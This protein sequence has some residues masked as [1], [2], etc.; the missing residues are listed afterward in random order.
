MDGKR[1][2]IIQLS[3]Q[4]KFNKWCVKPLEIIK[5]IPNGDGGF[6]ALVY[7]CHLYEKYVAIKM[8]KKKPTTSE[9]TG[10]L[11]I[12]FSITKSLA[13]QF[14]RLM[15]HGISHEAF[16]K[17]TQ[18]WSMVDGSLPIKE[19]II[20]EGKYKQKSINVIPFLF[21]D[22]VLSLFQENELYI[23]ELNMPNIFQVVGG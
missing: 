3:N 5:N 16:P 12:D 11:C 7:A 6:I 20:P 8:K 4:E 17:S 15:R 14:W 23:A 9:I 2:S 21:M 1:M 10:H 19:L 13:T 18:I 22:K